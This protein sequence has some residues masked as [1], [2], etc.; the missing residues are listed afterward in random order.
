LGTGID[1][2]YG[3]YTANSRIGA[4]LGLLKNI[5]IG[6]GSTSQQKLYDGYLKALIIRQCKKKY[7]VSLSL[8]SDATISLQDKN[9]PDE[10]TYT[11]QKL[12]YT[13][14][15]MV[16]RLFNERFAAQM[17]FALVHKNMVSSIQ[18]K[19]NILATGLAASYK[20]GRKI[21][22]AFEY[23]Y[24]LPNQIKSIRARQHIISVG[25]QIHTGPRHVFQIFL[26]NSSGI[27]ENSVITETTDKFRFKHLRI[28]FNIPTTFK[29]YN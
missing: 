14:E 8:F 13:S 18:D 11:W 9:Y 6:I 19:N 15:L 5:T 2:L 10:E 25:I 16:S 24:L 7:P 4:D 27:N 20:T 21:H 22:L 29:V 3:L 26:S 23:V 28:C 12:S 1:G 17:M